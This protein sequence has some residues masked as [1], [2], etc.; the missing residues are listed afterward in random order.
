MASAG[1]EKKN[2]TDIQLGHKTEIQEKKGFLTHCFFEKNNGS[3]LA[4]ACPN[5]KRFQESTIETSNENLFRECTKEKI[6]HL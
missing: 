2:E 4:L 1:E 3:K 6:F 5:I